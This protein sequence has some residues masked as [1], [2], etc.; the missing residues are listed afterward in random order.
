M[1][2]LKKFTRYIKE[3]NLLERKITALIHRPASLG[4]M[5]EYIA[6]KIFDIKLNASAVEKGFDGI[7]MGGNLKGK[8]VNIKWYAKNEGL[9]D[10]G[11]D[12]NNRPAYYLVLTGAKLNATSSRGRTRPWV[13]E[14][15][16]L[17]DADDLVSRL[18]GRVKIGIARSVKREFWEEAEI[19]PNQ[20]NTRLPLSDEQRCL[21]ALF[22]DS[23]AE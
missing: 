11:S 12:C 21:L 9:L 18:E 15:V 6:S 7:F 22:K 19:Y 2:D 13:I 5:G 16:Y 10:I 14:A 20:K 8:T 1:D 4:H 3:R 23:G 17:F